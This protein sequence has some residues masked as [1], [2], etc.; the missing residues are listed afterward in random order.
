MVVNFVRRLRELMQHE[1]S[2]LE[3]NDS[4][5][6]W[7][8]TGL[9]E[10]SHRMIYQPSTLTLFGEIDPSSLEKDF[11]IFDNKI[12]YFDSHIP[13]RLFSWLL[14]KEFKARSR[15]NS[16]WLNDLDPPGE[17][18]LMQARRILFKENLD[19]LTE[20]D[21]GAFQTAVFWASL[22]NTI[23]AL[24]WCL[25]YVLQDAKAI[26][27]IQR[28]IDTHLPFFSLDKDSDESLIKQWTPEQLSLCVH[29]DS[30]VNEILRLTGS[31]LVMRRCREETRVVLQDGRTL[32]VKPNEIVA[33][34][35]GV[36]HLDPNLF[37]EP[38]K[39]IFDR[40]VGKNPE[41]VPGFMPFGGG[42]SMCPGR[43]F[44]RNEMKISLAMLLRYIEYKFIDSTTIPTQKLERVGIGV[45]PP[46][47]DIPIMYRYKT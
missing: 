11:Q 5:S 20:R 40:F 7:I 45:S 3:S 13:R 39:F 1:K 43:F 44:A 22:G 36:N 38:N 12:Q 4:L 42:K 14:P 26:E 8:P 18:E 21:R 25:F 23:P 2:K 6:E 19:W 32:T 30:A 27:T 46:N 10:L 37:P 33:N 28:E 9:L 47:K 41:S 15:L 16:S 29:L 24:F 34:F 35:V 31:A 17:S